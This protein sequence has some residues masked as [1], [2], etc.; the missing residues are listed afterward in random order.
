MG[1]R[2]DKLAGRSAMTKEW[3]QKSI[4]WGNK[5]QPEKALVVLGNAPHASLTFCFDKCLC[6]DYGLVSKSVLSPN[7]CT[8]S[9]KSHHTCV[10]WQC[11]VKSWDF[12]SS[13]NK[14]CTS[15]IIMS[16]PVSG[17]SG[18]SCWKKELHKACQ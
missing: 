11:L 13:L 1:F 12:K 15:N 3:S 4:S 7:V 5:P 8:F 6:L 2:S 18:K 14:L 10:S 9:I 17:S 16:K